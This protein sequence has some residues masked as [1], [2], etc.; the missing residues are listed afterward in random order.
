V[1]RANALSLWAI[2]AVQLKLASWASVA[3]MCA[4]EEVPGHSLSEVLLELLRLGEHTSLLRSAELGCAAM[5]EELE[6]VNRS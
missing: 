5:W 6:G 1:I 3:L 2:A 4:Q